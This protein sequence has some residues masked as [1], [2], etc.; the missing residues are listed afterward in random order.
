MSSILA[1]FIFVIVERGRWRRSEWLS[2]FWIL[3]VRGEG[4]APEITVAEFARFDE[5]ENMY[6][7]G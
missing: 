2:R 6:F 7:V 5:L 1:G 4:R 3:L